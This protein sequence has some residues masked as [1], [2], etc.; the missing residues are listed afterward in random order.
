MTVPFTVSGTATGGGTDYSI[1]ASPVVITAGNTTA[2]ITITITQD[3]QYENDETVIV[4]M[5][6]PT[7]ATQGA[8]I[9][10][11]VTI[12]DDDV[13]PSV[14]FTSA[15]QS[16]GD[17]SAQDY[18]IT[19]ELS[20][21]SGMDVTVPFTVNAASTAT[22]GSTDYSITASPLTITAGTPSADIIV[23]IATDGEIEDDETVIVDMGT[24][25]NATL[26]ATT[27]HTLTITD[28]DSGG[29]PT[30]TVCVSPAG[31]FTTIQDAICLLY[32]S[33]A[34]DE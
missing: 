2:D 22:G 5:G 26:G 29:G 3:S 16:T 9:T 28:D 4:D 20:S 6:T 31:D 14:T 25:T 18:T 27:S 1:T 17:E 21:V 13:A 11:T 7:N 15:S 24:P 30:V 23:T 12:N 32:T 34:A 10:H 33:D 19:A 8:V